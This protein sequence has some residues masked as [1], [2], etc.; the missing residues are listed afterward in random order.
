M[1]TSIPSRRLRVSLLLALGLTALAVGP[2]CTQVMVAPD[3]RG[4]FKFGELQV[5]ADRD[6]TRVY[7]AAKSGLKDLKLFQTQDDRKV[8][9]AELRARDATD[10]LV[11]VKIKEVGKNRTSVKI[12]Y[13]IVKPDLA[14]AQKLYQAIEKHL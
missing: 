14:A 10:T 12:R 6:F 11:I 8:I 9:E 7:D 4:E 1:K 13:G 5:F 3:T 2:A